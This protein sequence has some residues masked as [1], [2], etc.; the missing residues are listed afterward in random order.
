M[1][2]KTFEGQRFGRLVTRRW[3]GAVSGNGH[4]WEC[5]CDCG[6]VTVAR[7]TNLTRG[8]TRSC[9]CLQRELAGKHITTHGHSGPNRTRTYRIW[10]N[11]KTR[12]TNPRSTGYHLYGERGITV[13][14]RWLKFE[15]FLR[16]MGEAPLALTLERK[17]NDKGYTKS[18]CKWATY[19]EQRMNQRRMK[20]G[21]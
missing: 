16:D 4:A 10:A 18:N 2:T 20:K 12:C 8:A 6:S 3:L 17:D 14:K 19:Y 9:G 5:V 15:N 11:M 1:K 7:T 21:L 13:C